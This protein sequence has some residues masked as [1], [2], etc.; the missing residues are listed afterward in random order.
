M[1]EG[2][3]WRL[4]AIATPGHAANHLAFALAG[5][6][7]IFTGDHVMGWSTT[8]VAP[9]DGSMAD[10]MAS[11]DRLL[12]RPEKTYVPGHG[13]PIHEGPAFVRAL[14]SHRRMRE[15]AILDRL[16]KGDRT[17]AELVGA[18]YRDTDPRLHAAAGLSVLAHLEDLT[19]RGRVASEGPPS[20]HGVFR[21]A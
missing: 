16:A 3:G 12:D 13:G 1:V 20:I 9:P 21:P 14:R 15:A 17:I 2:D 18:I 7:A 5:T 8:V 6:D 19:A 4:E 11:L 10:Y